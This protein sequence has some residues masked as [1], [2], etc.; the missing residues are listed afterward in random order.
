MACPLGVELDRELLYL[1]A[2]EG[3]S[4]VGERHAFACAGIEDEHRP[5]AGH[6]C[7]EGSFERGFI[8][9]EVSVFHEIAG[10]PRENEG[11]G[12]LL[13]GG[14]ERRKHA[15]ACFRGWVKPLPLPASKSW[16]DRDRR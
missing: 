14:D 8:R 13:V 5:V 15:E 10:E 4:S 3:M 16:P 6:Q 7:V 9:G 2:S 1:L 12:S 11:H